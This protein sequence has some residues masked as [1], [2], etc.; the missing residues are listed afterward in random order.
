M[1][2]LLIIFCC[3]LNGGG[4][5]GS[6]LHKDAPTVA[7]QPAVISQNDVTPLDPLLDKV[8]AINEPT[9]RIFLRVKI[10]TYLWT[11]P[12][13]SHNSPQSVAGDTLADLD[14]HEKEIPDVY[15][16]QFRRELLAQLKAHAP[17]SATDS[18]GE[19]QDRPTDLEVAYSLLGQENG[20]D[21]AV[22]M[23][24]RSIAG[25]RDPE[26]II[27]PFLHRLEKISPAKVPDVLDTILSAEESRPNSISTGTLFTLKHLIIREQTPQ[28]LQRRFIKAVMR[29]A[30][31]AES[32]PAALVDTYAILT[33]LLPTIEVLSPDLYGAAGAQ[34]SQLAGQVPS[35]TRARLSIEKRMSQSSDPLAFLMAE[36]EAV[37]DASLKEDLQIRAAQLALERGQV[38][39]AIDLAVKANPNNKEAMLW[40]DQFVEEAVGQAISRGEVEVA[41]YGARHVQSVGVRV[42]VLQKIAIHFQTSNDWSGARETLNS[43]ITLTEAMTDNADKA[44]ALLD[45][46]GSSLKADEQQAHD[47]IRA[48]IRTI[49]KTPAARKVKAEDVEDTM[50]IAYR[51]IPTF[52]ALSVAYKSFALDQAEDIQRP[53]LKTAASV[54]VFTGPPA[55]NDKKQR[56][57]S[58]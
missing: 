35:G 45:L 13:A 8:K 11:N 3:A 58:N 17:G 15:A 31:Q 41:Q 22:A 33:D 52:Q 20:A 38:R 9:L 48:A 46:A 40:R 55:A 34:Q 43:A 42:S 50:K 5:C 36:K 53:E 37:T 39:T 32:D 25:G 7:S 24:Q 12:A 19:E 16:N 28:G 51:I 29:R 49:N 23:M 2:T 57:A 6:R 54:G 47:L 10:A 30:G 14:A 27:V 56:T 1:T 4:S 21:K 26:G 18:A 44:A